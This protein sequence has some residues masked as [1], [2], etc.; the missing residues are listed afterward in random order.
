MPARLLRRTEAARILGISKT[1]LRRMEGTDLRPVIGPKNVR[2]FD[3]EQVQ[4]LVITKRRGV[5]AEVDDGGLAAEVFT[6]FDAGSDPVDVVRTLR[7]SPDRVEA[8]HRQWARLRGLL[9]LSAAGR[10]SV[11]RS[12]DLTAPI[13]T[14]AQFLE[15]LEAWVQN[16]TSRRCGCKH[17]W[18]AFCRDCA[19]KWGRS[20]ARLEAITAR[21]RRL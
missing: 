20:V 6:L 11:R 21:E 14:E 9:V 1:Q 5:R 12:L 17:E 7:A 16:D 2:L 19:R 18:A 10:D 4:A 13:E 8:L 15:V 3:E